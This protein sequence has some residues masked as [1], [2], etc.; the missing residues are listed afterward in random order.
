[1]TVGYAPGSG[2]DIYSRLVARHLGKHI[3]G[4]PTVV[5]QNMPGA[6]S[7]KAA[8][9]MFAAAPRDGSMLG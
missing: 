1:M 4:K 9:Y 3:P 6:G 2:N 8:N 7:Y 5:T